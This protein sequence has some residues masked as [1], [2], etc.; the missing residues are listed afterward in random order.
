VALRAQ[1]SRRPAA[2]A[3]AAQL[4]RELD[5]AAQVLAQK[6]L[7]LAG[8]RTIPDRCSSLIDADARPIRQGNPRR[9]TE[10]AYKARVAHP[11]GGF[12]IAD[13]PDKGN[14]NDDAL[15]GD[16]IAKA[17]RACGSTACWQ[18]GAWRR[19]VRGDAVLRGRRR[20]RGHTAAGTGLAA[21]GHVR[22]DTN[23]GLPLDAIPEKVD[24]AQ[25]ENSRAWRRASCLGSRLLFGR[26]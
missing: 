3:L 22:V 12:V 6:D 19:T 25:E 7:R 26:G 2:S 14:P 9:P 15:L 20:L 8:R 1:R 13:V 18:T 24:G 23:T 21:G 10:F 11:A 4:Q 5:V 17:R 16:A